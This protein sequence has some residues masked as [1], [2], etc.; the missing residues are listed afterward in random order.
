MQNI[1][2][3]GERVRAR[4]TATPASGS[5]SMRV[6]WIILW[7]VVAGCGKVA[8]APDA[9]RAPDASA[10]AVVPDGA[11]PKT[12]VAVEGTSTFDAAMS[13]YARVAYTTVAYDDRGE[14]DPSTSRFTASHAGDFQ[15]CAS[16]AIPGVRFELDLFVNGAEEKALGGGITVADG[17]RVIRLAAGDTVEIW[18]FQISLATATVSNDPNWNWLGIHEI[19]ALASLDN[20][21]PFGAVNIGFTPVPYGS[22]EFDLGNEYDTGTNTFTASAAGDYQFCTSL[23]SASARFESDLFING[24]RE[25]AV[26]AG[27]I[28]TST[29]CRVVRLVA[30]DTVQIEIFQQS[31]A[32]VDVAPHPWWDWLTIARSPSSVSVGDIST[33]AVPSMTFTRVPYSST[34]YDDDH[35]F[36]ASAGRFTPSV[37]GDYEIC[38]SMYLQSAGTF[39][40]DI[41]KNGTRE[42]GLALGDSIETGCRVVRLAAGDHVDVWTNQ[43]SGGTLTITPNAMWDWLTARRVP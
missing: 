40:L 9:D 10:D 33:F 2:T 14:F 23:Y 43:D 41:F 22:T 12:A 6:A 17:C 25:R 15:V 28:E 1:S 34:L 20:I 19:T 4:E 26:A 21:S 38:A 24:V 13:T 5:G 31:G 11:P 37:A 39:E 42:K 16:L 29:G 8:S 18:M 7:I 3:E 27:T 36:D 30:G 32:T 35:L